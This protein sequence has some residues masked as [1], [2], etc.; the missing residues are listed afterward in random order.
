VVLITANSLIFAHDITVAAET[1]RMDPAMIGRFALLGIYVG[2]IPVFLGI[3][4]LPFLR[5]LPRRWYDFLLNL[6]AGLLVFLG[7]D[8]LH[9]A[10]EAAEMVRRSNLD[11]R[12]A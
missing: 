9:E 6:T 5:T 12:D 3:G 10:L 8:S 2:V 4:W 7:V 1:P 11:G